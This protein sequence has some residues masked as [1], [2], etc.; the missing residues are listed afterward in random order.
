MPGFV[1]DRGVADRQSSGMQPLSRLLAADIARLRQLVAGDDLVRFYLAL[2]EAEAARGEDASLVMLGRVRRGA[3]LGARFDGIAVF[4][5]V[6]ELDDADLSALLDWP[7]RL[8]LH[9][10]DLHHARLGRLSAQGLG[11]GRRMVAMEAPTRGAAPDPEALILDAAGFAAAAALMAR[12]NPETVLSARM[13]ALPFAAIV[14]SGR[15]LAM[16]GTI[17]TA[18]EEAMIGHFLT[19]P[20]ARGR[21]LARRLALHL[22]WHFAQSGVTRL[23]LATTEDNRPACRAYSAAG[24]SVSGRRWQVGRDEGR[25]GAPGCA[26]GEPFSRSAPRRSTATDLQ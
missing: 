4:S 5:T 25:F 16:A 20:E 3:A 7:G 8:E 22:R 17:G 11:P 23:L 18:G 9:L 15:I 12:S 19:V 13:A 6:G 21:G 10:T 26:L 2:A 1:Q 14:E 24:F